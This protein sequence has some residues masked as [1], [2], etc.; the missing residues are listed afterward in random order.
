M[1]KYSRYLLTLIAVFALAFVMKVPVKAY[2]ELTNVKQ[3]GCTTNSI[4]VSWTGPTTTNGETITNCIVKTA[5][6]LYSTTVNAYAGTATLN[7]SSNYVGYIRIYTY[8]KTSYGSENYAYNSTYCNT[9]PTAPGKNSFALSGVYSYSSKVAFA[10]ARNN[11]SHKTQ[12]QLYKG[13]KLYKT[14]NF[15]SYSDSIPVTKGA[16]Y[17]YRARFYY[18]NDSLG[19]TYCSKWSPWRGFAMCKDVKIRSKSNKKGYTLTMKKASGV[20]KYVVKTSK[21][22]DSGYKK[23]KTFKAKSKKSYTISVTKNYSKKKYNYI[24]I[25]PYISLKWYKG[26]SD[27]IIKGSCYVYK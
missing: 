18:V 25:Q 2:V 24:Q 22:S 26:A 6:D 15:S 12:I 14:F 1:K 19:K 5:D 13:N 17:Q 20:T 21:N 16:S 11:S 10:S 4:T 27:A 9:V 7:V 3:T 8:Y 23:S